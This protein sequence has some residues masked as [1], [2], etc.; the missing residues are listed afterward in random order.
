MGSGWRE[1]SGERGESERRREGVG[2]RGR[3]E[4]RGRERW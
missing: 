3:K 4:K 2:E 1:G